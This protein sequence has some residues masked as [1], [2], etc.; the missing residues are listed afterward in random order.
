MNRHR[1]IQNEEY[2]LILIATLEIDT[3]GMLR[4]NRQQ[5]FSDLVGHHLHREKGNNT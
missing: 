5:L 1:S 3:H 4:T 2:V